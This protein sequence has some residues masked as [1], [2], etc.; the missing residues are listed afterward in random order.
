[1]FRAI[2]PT[3]PGETI[4]T[5]HPATWASVACQRFTRSGTKPTKP[6]V[7]APWLAVAASTARVIQPGSAPA[8]VAI[9]L[10]S[11]VKNCGSSRQ[12]ATTPPTTASRVRGRSRSSRTSRTA[13]CGRVRSTSARIASSSSG[14]CLRSARVCRA[15]AI[16]WSSGRAAPTAAGPSAATPEPTACS[17]PVRRARVVSSCATS[18]RSTRSLAAMSPSARSTRCTAPHSATRTASGTSARC[19]IRRVCSSL[20][21][22]QTSA[23]SSSVSSSSASRPRVRPGTCS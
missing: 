22:A 16:G 18:A 4:L 5:K 21:C 1:M 14:C 9:G 3:P 19:E 12:P 15:S 11:V 2:P 6:T 7:A 17:A 20:N 8:R 10:W 23:S 13:A